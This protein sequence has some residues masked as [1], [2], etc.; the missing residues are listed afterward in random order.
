[1]EL[2][3]RCGERRQTELRI[4]QQELHRRYL[5]SGLPLLDPRGRAVVKFAPQAR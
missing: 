3:P 5:A 4:Q 1:M 2:P